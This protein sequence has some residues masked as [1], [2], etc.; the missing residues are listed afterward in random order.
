MGSGRADRRCD[1]RSQEPASQS[2]ASSTPRTQACAVGFP[3]KRLDGM[4]AIAM[5]GGVST[6]ATRMRGTSDHPRREPPVRRTFRYVMA[7]IETEANNSMLF[8]GT[9]ASAGWLTMSLSMFQ[10]HHL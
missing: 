2:R 5:A 1:T 8:I 6:P 7:P 10:V 9:D 3:L 4:P